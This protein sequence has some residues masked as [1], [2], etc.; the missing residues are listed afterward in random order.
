M[1][2]WAAAAVAGPTPP[3]NGGGRGKWILIGLALVAVI[4]ISV[5]ATVL[6]LRRDSDTAA[7][8]SAPHGGTQFASANDTG[9]A[10]LITEDPTCQAWSKVATDYT[11][12]TKSVGWAERDPKVAAVDWTAQQR[13]MYET[14]SEALSHAVSF[15]PNLEKQTPHRV[16]RELYGQF[17]AAAHAWIDVVPNY[18]PNHNAVANVYGTAM[19]ALSAICAAIDWKS[20]QPLAPLVN[21]PAPPTNPLPVS[22]PA[23]GETIDESV[24]IC[25]DWLTS[26]TTFD[27]HS[28]AWLAIDANI[29]A[30]DW[31]PE[32]KAVYDA[33]GPV[34]TAHAD[35]IEAL[36]R[37]SGDPIMEDFAVLAA[38][39][40]RA[41][42]L[43]IPTYRSA[44]NYVSDATRFLRS[45]LLWA[46]RRSA[47]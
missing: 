10:N 24:P 4:A 37:R 38:Q 41:Y 17:E 47:P 2:S 29:P 45:T 36:G 23:T 8:S 22:S 19:S 18:N 42:V 13:S 15:A 6:G 9:P 40:L 7:T 34:M 43:A 11:A 14:V 5:A 39:Y 16:M 25:R 12:S 28:A 31:T 20:I 32:Q 1:A 21:P 27:D 46:C 26:A 33:V 30:S 35:E 44:D 3:T